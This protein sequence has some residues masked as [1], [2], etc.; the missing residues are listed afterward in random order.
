M[1]SWASG[2]S[3]VRTEDMAP[4]PPTS[5]WIHIAFTY[6]G[7]DQKL[8]L[9][10]QQVRTVPSTGSVTNDPSGFNQGLNIGARYTGGTQYVEGLIDNAR[11]HDV[12][13]APMDLGFYRDASQVEIR[14]V[15]A[16]PAQVAP[17][18]GGAA[19]SFDAENTGMNT[20]AVTAVDLS[21]AD[22]GG[23]DVSSEY[24]VTPDPAN[25][26][27]IAA[28]ATENFAFAVDVGAMA[29]LGTIDIDGSFDGIDQVTMATSMDR[30]ADTPDAWDVV[31]A[32]VELRTVDAPDTMVSQGGTGYPVTV[33][34]ENVGLNSAIVGGVGLTFTGSADRTAEYTVTPAPGNP[35]VI[36]PATTESFAFSVDVDPGASLETITLDGVFTGVDSVSGAAIIDND[37][38]LTDSWVVVLCG[39][40]LCGDC[41][42]DGFVTILDALTAA[43]HSAAIITL[44][45]T[46]FTNCNVIGAVEPDPAAAVDILDALTLAQ[47]AAGLPVMLVCC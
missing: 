31:G 26:T 30:A 32:L 24:V 21:F 46:D 20:I 47:S 29:T 25:P 11:I 9:N 1:T 42:G 34:A 13:L 10:G 35:V 44:T 38:D 18:Q 39:A 37:A 7:S 14:T 4:F 17:G 12:A 8:Y 6:D 22:S 41:N 23:V 3:P 40:T 16:V 43:Q 19:V 36:A 5:S 15:S 2:L 45:G 28:G 33:A 27:T